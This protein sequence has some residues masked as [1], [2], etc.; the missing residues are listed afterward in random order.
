M[1]QIVILTVIGILTF[2]SIIQGQTMTHSDTTNNSQKNQTDIATLAGGCFWCL[3]P[4][5]EELKG[6]EN[7]VVGYSGGT[8]A[9]PTYEQVCTG[10]TGHAESVQI[11]FNPEVI[12]YADLLRVFFTVHDPTTLNRQGADVGTQYRSA[13]F[14]H[15][16]QQKE[17]AEKVIKELEDKGVW[18]NPIVTE[19]TKYKTFYKAEKYHQEYYEKNP[20]QAY[21]RIVIDPKVNKFRKKFSDRLKKK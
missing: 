6:V 3:Q 8:V 14:Y 21:C 10:K 4:I 17:T 11:T 7:V 18:D 19:V 16:Q 2:G 12:S 9:N 20:N 13:I 5:F 1:K 15:N